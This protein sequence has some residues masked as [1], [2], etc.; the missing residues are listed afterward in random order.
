MSNLPQDSTNVTPDSKKCTT[1]IAGTSQT[2]RGG[3]G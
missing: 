3:S 2:A 1:V